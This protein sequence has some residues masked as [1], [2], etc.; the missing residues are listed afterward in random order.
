MAMQQHD[1]NR[2]IINGIGSSSRATMQLLVEETTKRRKINTIHFGNMYWTTKTAIFKL[3]ANLC[4]L[5]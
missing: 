1:N 4:L 3:F 5:N 2:T